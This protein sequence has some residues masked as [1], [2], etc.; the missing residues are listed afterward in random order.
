V[1]AGAAAGFDDKTLS[2]SPNM[3]GLNSID[4][5]VITPWGKVFVSFKDNRLEINIPEGVRTRINL[6]ESLSGAICH[7]TPLVSSK[8][9]FVDDRTI[10][11]EDSGRYILLK[12]E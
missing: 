6:P 7:E 11:L 10:H 1:F 2:I 3:Y 9:K 4:G 5:E 8:C 12:E